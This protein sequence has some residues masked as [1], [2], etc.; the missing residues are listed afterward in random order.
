VSTFGPTAEKRD[1]A[2]ILSQMECVLSYMLQRAS[3][4][5]WT[6]V[7][8]ASDALENEHRYKFPEAS[9]SAQLRHL[10]KPK[11]GS[12]NVM[13]RR[14]PSGIGEYLVVSSPKGQATLDFQ[15]R[16]L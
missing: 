13:R 5:R 9:V 2:R 10:R 15:G 16:S 11:F 7:E 8:E 12:W 1:E 3:Q 6:T 4:G 14:R